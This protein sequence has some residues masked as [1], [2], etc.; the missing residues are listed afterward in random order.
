MHQNRGEVLD[1]WIGEQR[2]LGPSR[3]CTDTDTDLPVQ[4]PLVGLLKTSQLRQFRKKSARAI[5]WL[6]SNQTIVDWL[7]FSLSLSC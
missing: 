3:T 5:V 4:H 2:R 1:S 6:F 7:D